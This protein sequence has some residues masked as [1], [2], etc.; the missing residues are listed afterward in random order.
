MCF[1]NHEQLKDQDSDLIHTDGD[2]TFTF[3]DSAITANGASGNGADVA[4]GSGWS[5]NGKRSGSTSEEALEREFDLREQELLSR[6]TRLVFPMEDHVWPCPPPHLR[7]HLTDP[8]PPSPQLA[9][10]LT[11][12]GRASCPSVPHRSDKVEMWE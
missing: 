10:Y 7:H 11:P 4:G 8:S 12:T 2:L 3:G 1:Q 5:A 9:A 6:G